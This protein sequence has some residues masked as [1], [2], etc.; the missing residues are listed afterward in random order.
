MKPLG[1]MRT[2]EIEYMDENN[3]LRLFRTRA[4]TMSEVW[5][6]DHKISHVDGVTGIQHMIPGSRITSIK[7][8]D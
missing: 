4:F 7:E 6:C 1:E 3:E 5:N 8:V 2:Y